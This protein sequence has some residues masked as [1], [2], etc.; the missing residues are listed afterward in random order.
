M[1]K[2]GLGLALLIAGALGACSSDDAPGGGS[3]NAGNA[4]AGGSSGSAGSGGASGSGGAAGSGGSAG[5]SGTAGSAGAA[6]SGGAPAL[7]SQT[8]LYADIATETLAAGVESYEPSYPLYSDGATKKRWL[9][10]PPGS[11]IDTTDM[12]YWVYPVGTKVWKEFTRDGT[13]IETRMLQ[14]IAAPDDW[15]MV[16]YQWNTAQTEAQAVP[17]GVQNAAGTEHDI[18]SESDCAIC[19]GKMKDRL[20]SVSAIQLSHSKPG[21]TLS[22]LSSSGRL[23]NAPAGDFAVPGDATAQAALG[24]LHANCGLCHNPQSFVFSQVDMSLWL[25]TSEL[26]SVTDTGTYKTTV[27]QAL[28]ASNPTPSTARIVA[29]D[30]GASDIHYRMNERGTLTQMP[31]LGSEVVD[32]AG[33]AAI[34]AWIASL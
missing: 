21:V 32:A 18:P 16:A 7:L 1:S 34:D 14:K 29:G 20:L 4:G 3:G 15:V 8:G 19:H 24:Y 9:Y 2:T 11:Q 22:S 33:L 30:P 26:G 23:A 28:T 25:S 12:D 13:R 27:G 31:P 5:A 17:A 10:L 6:G